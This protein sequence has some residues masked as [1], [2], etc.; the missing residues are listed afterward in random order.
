MACSCGPVRHVYKSKDLRYKRSLYS[1]PIL[2]A[3]YLVDWGRALEATGEGILLGGV[4]IPALLFADDLLLC[5]ESPQA[6]RR[7]LDVSEREARAVKAVISEKKSMVIS[8][9]ITTWDLHDEKGEVYSSLDKVLS[10]KYLGVEVF[11][12]MFRVSSAKQKKCVQAAERYRGA[13]RYLSRQGPDVVDLSVVAWRRQAVPAIIFGTENIIFSDTTIEAL[14]RVQGAWARNTLNLPQT[15]P[16]VAAQLLLGAPTFKQM[17]YTSQLKAFL[18]LTQLPSNRYAAHALLEHEVGGWKSPYLEYMAKIQMDLGIMQ[19]PPAKENIIKVVENLFERR[20]KEKVKSLTSVPVLQERVTVTR[21]RSARE[22]EDWRW[23]N[24]AIM[25]ATGIQYDREKSLWRK[26]CPEDG[27]LN[28]DLHC[29]SECGATARIRKATGLSLYFASCSLK[30]L[31]PAQAY[32][33][34]VLGLDCRGEEVPEEDYRERG[35]SLAA[36]F[37]SVMGDNWGWFFDYR[38]KIQW[39]NWRMRLEGKNMFD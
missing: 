17:L 23:V 22:G 6:L 10:Y 35:R 8:R 31:T 3:L 4:R 33:N 24:R 30:G 36:V 39:L 9:A 18:R 12:T 37:K 26:R 25:G 11:N 7:L 27:A 20:L 32:S 2:F 13:T 29:M 16:G 1:S 21:A 14:E 38:C 5:A 28:S 15:C 34:L 19:L